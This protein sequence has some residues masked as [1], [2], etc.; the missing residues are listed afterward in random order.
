MRSPLVALLLCALAAGAPAEP[1]LY[2]LDP[3]HSFVNFELTHFGTST[4]RGRIG[5]LRGSVTL[6]REAGRGSVGLGVDMG[7]V[8][9]GLRVFDSRIREPDLLATTDYPQAYFVAERF[10]FERQRLV[11]VRGEFTLRGVS[12]ALSLRALHFACEQR[13]LLQRE[14]CGGDFE[15]E[16]KRSEFGASYGMPFVSDR[17]RLLVQVEGIRQ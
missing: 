5:P 10:R 8:S 7:S 2:Q 15:A 14:V 12:Q 13:E 3:N 16:L 4:I 1:V 17:V 6:D 11:E 9:T